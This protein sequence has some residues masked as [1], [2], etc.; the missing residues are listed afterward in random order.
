MKLSINKTSII[1]FTVQLV[2]AVMIVFGIPFLLNLSTHQQLPLN[3]MYGMTF[4]WTLPFTFIYFLNFYL[5]VPYL[6][7]RKHIIL[8]GILN[9]A[10]ILLINS[11]MFSF[12]VAYDNAYVHAGFNMFR[13]IIILIDFTTVGLALGIR[14]I[15][16]AGR[17]ELELRETKQKNAEA[18]LMWLK[19]QLNPHFL[20]NALNNISS[21]TQI[22]ADE[23]Q[24]SI[25]RLSDLLRYAMYETKN[26]KVA[27]GK[28]VEFMKNYISMMK[29]RC[30]DKTTVTTTFDIENPELEIAPMLFISVI[31][32]GFKHGVSNTHESFVT[33][34]MKQSGGEVTFS[35]R[36][37]DFHKL[38]T[39]RSGSGVGIENTL[40]RLKL[41]YKDRFTW[42]QTTADGIF[43]TDI[44]MKL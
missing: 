31:E 13:G 32:N 10:I 43:I 34:E 36:N 8:F 26:E 4:P 1:I 35:C 27:I 24:D 15:M 6:F 44:K 11:P 28:E 16:K 19:N 5:F 7:E 2:L 29:L 9:I 17:V 41:I 12:K 25:A 39:D 22:D 30:T 14:Y 20:F 38:D 37:S 3:V 18:E 40:R 21:L 33:I 42:R 23:A